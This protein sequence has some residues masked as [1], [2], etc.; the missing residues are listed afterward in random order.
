[1]TWNEY[2]QYK[3]IEPVPLQFVKEGRDDKRQSAI[4]GPK[5]I[6]SLPIV[7]F[8]IFLLDKLISNIFTQ[9][10]HFQYFY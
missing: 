5:N 3:A 10:T 9:Q 2:T 6:C 7:K 4:Y 1:M 8:P